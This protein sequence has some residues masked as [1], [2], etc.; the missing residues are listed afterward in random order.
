MTATSPKPQDAQ[1]IAMTSRQPMLRAK[2]ERF[3][4]DRA[5]GACVTLL[6]VCGR[7]H[8]KPPHSRPYEA[9]EEL[10]EF[11]A[12]M[13]ATLRAVAP[14]AS[15]GA[16]SEAALAVT[17]LFSASRVTLEPMT[18]SESGKVVALGR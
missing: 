3:D 9:R 11:G 10:K 6:E 5:R 1:I 7:L 4:S 16:L 13:F 15:N 18:E 17:L 8:A 14:H 12:A 2:A